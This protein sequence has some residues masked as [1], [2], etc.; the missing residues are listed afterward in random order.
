MDITRQL[1]GKVIDMVMTNGSI[2]SFR[3]ADG[4]HFDIAMV[5]DNGNALK[6]RFVVA[7]NGWR[8]RANA[9]E[10]VS[11]REAGVILKPY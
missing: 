2:L 4:A 5:D 11:G 8:M 9:K 1:R 6:G 10:I 7:R 3:M